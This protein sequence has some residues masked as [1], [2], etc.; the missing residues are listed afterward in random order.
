MVALATWLVAASVPGP[1]V[2]PARGGDRAY[3]AAT[4][5]IQPT[6]TAELGLALQ[7]GGSAPASPSDRPLAK[8]TQGTVKSVSTTAPDALTAAP[9]SRATALSR[10]AAPATPAPVIPAPATPAPPTPAPPTPAPEAPL[11]SRAAPTRTVANQAT[12][13]ARGPGATPHRVRQSP[14]QT[15]PGLLGGLLQILGL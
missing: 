15:S 10:P 12:P 8:P 2:A 7:Q 1:S 4:G 13:G 11:P 5:A 3:V 14:G 6:V 9:P